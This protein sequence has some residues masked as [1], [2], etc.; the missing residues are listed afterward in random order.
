MAALAAQGPYLPT[1][2]PADCRYC[3]FAAICR[4][5]PGE[6]GGAESPPAAWMKR[7]GIHLPEGRGVAWL[8]GLDG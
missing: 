3:D 4:A 1:E 5:V 6:H 2:D 7:I 8:R